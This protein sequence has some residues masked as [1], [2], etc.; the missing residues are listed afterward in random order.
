MIQIR[1]VLYRIRIEPLHARSKGFLGS[2]ESAMDF[3]IF[4]KHS[5]HVRPSRIDTCA[6]T[7]HSNLVKLTKRNRKMASSIVIMYTRTKMGRFRDPRK[8]SML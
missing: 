1:A 6:A 5:I 8:T 4:S 3:I 2:E 7:F